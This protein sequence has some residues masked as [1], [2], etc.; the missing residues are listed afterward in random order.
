MGESMKVDYLGLRDKLKNLFVIVK[1]R[2]F[3]VTFTPLGT[4]RWLHEFV[5]FFE[6]F[7]AIFLRKLK[8]LKE[9][10]ES[11]WNWFLGSFGSAQDWGRIRYRLVW[12]LWLSWL[13]AINTFSKYKIC[14]KVTLSIFAPILRNLAGETPLAPP[15]PLSRFLTELLLSFSFGELPW[16]WWCCCFCCFGVCF[17]FAFSSAFWWNST[18]LLNYKIFEFSWRLW[19]NANYAISAALS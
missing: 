7:S 1:G 12:V 18:S 8:S 11:Q 3:D 19:A 4:R 2:R 17:A 13:N 16:C 5:V 14:P 9:T 15:P 10:T 6:D